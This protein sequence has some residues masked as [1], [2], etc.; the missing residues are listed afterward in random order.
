MNKCN[1]N[2]C[3]EELFWP[4]IFYI[5]T[6]LRRYDCLYLKVNKTNTMKRLVNNSIGFYLN[7]GQIKRFICYLLPIIISDKTIIQMSNLK[8]THHENF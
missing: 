8:K 1:S 5:V 2:P 6:D 4:S 7:N 3:F